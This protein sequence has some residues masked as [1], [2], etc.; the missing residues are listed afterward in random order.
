ML[1]ELRTP[2]EI[3]YADEFGRYLELFYRY[4]PKKPF[5]VRTRYG[6]GFVCQKG[7]KKTGEEYYRGCYPAL[8]ARMLDHDRRRLVVQPK[9]YTAPHYWIALNTGRKSALKAIDF[10][11]KQNLLGYY[12]HGAPDDWSPRPLPTLNLEHLQ[13]VKRLYDAF[14]GHTWCVSSATLG[15]HAWEKLLRPLPIDA[16]QAG[17]RPR[18]RE[19]G[20]GSTEIHPMFG[21]PFRRPFGEDYYTITDS[22]LLERWTDQLDYFG[23]VAQPPSFGAIYQAMRSLLVE[24]WGGYVSYR[25]ME[26]LSPTT[27]KPHLLKYFREKN[28]INCGQLDEDLK[29]LD[30]WAENGFPQCLPVSVPVMTDISH[31]EP[32]SQQPTKA[33]D[34][35]SKAEESGCDIDMSAVCDSQWVQNCEKWAKDGLPCHDSVFQVVS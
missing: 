8:I 19:I 21:R 24:E 28:H 23:N 7:K 3:V 25:K 4:L 16:I 33:D 9:E 35:S 26:K 1:E 27:G 22:G 10:D 13:A 30:S 34:V 6:G 14:P 17:N 20:L 5:H 29:V 11:N 12:Q 31:L 15:L 18:L 32:V 2:L